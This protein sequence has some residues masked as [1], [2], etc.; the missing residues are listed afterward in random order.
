V[1]G[2]FPIQRID[3]SPVAQPQSIPWDLIAPHERQAE[4]N[5][6][7]TLM[8]LA[9]R[10]GLSVTEALA[11]IEDRSWHRVDVAE[12]VEKLE[13]LEHRYNAV[14]MLKP[15]L[16]VYAECKGMGIA[17]R[18]VSFDKTKGTALVDF[19]GTYGIMEA[20]LDSVEPYDLT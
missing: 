15:G 19:H 3:D 7:Q 13:H 11:V 18:L 12:A 20:P 6:D 10:G 2:E 14:R 17:G 5:H 16:K 1:L 4:L 9:R 8:E